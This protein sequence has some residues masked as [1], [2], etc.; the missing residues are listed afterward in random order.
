MFRNRN[1]FNKLPFVHT[2]HFTEINFIL[3]YTIAIE[4]EIKLKYRH[5]ARILRA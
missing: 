2:T 5:F 4:Y 3:L 1:N